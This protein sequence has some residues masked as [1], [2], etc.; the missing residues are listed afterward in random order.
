MGMISDQ[1]FN[2]ILSVLAQI[3]DSYPDMGGTYVWEYFNAPTNWHNKVYSALH[4]NIIWRA[5][6]NFVNKFTDFRPFIYWMF[7]QADLSKK[8]SF[9]EPKYEELTIDELD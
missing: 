7:P 2:N 5:F 3:K 6:K 9:D 4:K 8:I 1:D